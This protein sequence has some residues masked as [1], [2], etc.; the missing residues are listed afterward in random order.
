MRHYIDSHLV[1]FECKFKINEIL[2]NISHSL[3]ER[4][5]RYFLL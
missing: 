5:Q 1:D 4:N 2:K 3:V